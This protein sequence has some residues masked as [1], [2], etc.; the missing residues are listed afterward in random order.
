MVIIKVAKNIQLIFLIWL[1]PM[2]WG[3]ATNIY[4]VKN[5]V[6]NSITNFITCKWQQKESEFQESGWI[7]LEWSDEKHVYILWSIN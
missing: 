4:Q 5:F 6:N 2:N 1:T 3:W 7:L